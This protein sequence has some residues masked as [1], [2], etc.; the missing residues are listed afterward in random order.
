MIPEQS[1]PREPGDESLCAQAAAGDRRAEETLVVRYNRLVRMCAR[2]YFLAGG[3]SEDLIQ[4]G[5]VGLLGAIREYD[6]NKAA[7]FRTYAE[8]CVKNRLF[9]AVKAAARDKHTPLNNSVSFENPLFSGTGER[10]ACG[11]P[12]RQAEDPEEIILSREAFRERMKALHGQL[13]GF[14]ASVLRLYL[15][16]LSYSEIAA[17]V[18]KSP[19]SV[20]NA[21]QRIRRKLAQQSSSGDISAS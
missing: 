15:N 16:G 8:I 17:E 14:E 2:P 13:S 19:K 1:S 12:D 6:P 3:D 10:F 4:E 5:M 9:S 18:N 11:T 7:S 21:V 20:D